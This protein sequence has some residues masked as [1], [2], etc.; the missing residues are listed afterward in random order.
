MGVWPHTGPMFIIYHMITCVVVCASERSAIH[1]RHG[2]SDFPLP[3]LPSPPPHTQ[4]HSAAAAAAAAA[5]VAAAVAGKKS[6]GSIRSHN[7]LNK[8]SSL[9]K[10]LQ[11]TIAAVCVSVCKVLPCSVDILAAPYCE[12]ILYIFQVIDS[13]LGTSSRWMPMPLFTIQRQ[14]W[15]H[16]CVRDCFHV[17]RSVLCFAASDFAYTSGAARA[18]CVCACVCACMATFLCR[19]VFL[20]ITSDLI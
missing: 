9:Q 5:A 13:A 6:F 8:P 4:T 20:G 14:S 19:N 15:W 1:E 2:S 16:V 10:T 12:W 7:R 3:T 11:T 18:V 17:Q